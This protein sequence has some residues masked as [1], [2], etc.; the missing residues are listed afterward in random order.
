M[1]SI[2]HIEIGFGRAERTFYMKFHIYFGEIAGFGAFYS[3][4]HIEWTISVP[5]E[6]IVYE[7][8]YIT[9]RNRRI[10]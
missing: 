4:F 3:I 9:R 10:W 2:F 5:G 8:S 6:I 7:I 1:Y